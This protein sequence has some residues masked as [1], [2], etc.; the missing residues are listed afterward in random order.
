MKRV[1]CLFC[2]CIL[3]LSLVLTCELLQDYDWSDDDPVEGGGNNKPSGD[4][5]KFNEDGSIEF[6]IIPVP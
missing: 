3:A 6:P 4:D 1:I 2:A 5:I